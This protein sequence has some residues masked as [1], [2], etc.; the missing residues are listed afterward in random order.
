MIDAIEGGAFG[1]IESILHIGIGGSALGPDLIIDALGR[2]ADRFEVRVLSNIDG[3]AFDE[4]TWGLDPASTLIVAV[5]KTFTTTETL[6]NL[7]TALEWLR[8]AGVV[9][10]LLTA[11]INVDAGSRPQVASSNASPSILLNTRTS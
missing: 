4:A 9:K 7:E 10:V 1:D 5:S 8:E 6:T 2:D 3:E 11:T